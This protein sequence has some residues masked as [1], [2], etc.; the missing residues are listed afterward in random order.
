MNGDKE[1]QNLRVNNGM[2]ENGVKVTV[3]M[4]VFYMKKLQDQHWQEVCKVENQLLER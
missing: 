4:P 2:E 1:I 3:D